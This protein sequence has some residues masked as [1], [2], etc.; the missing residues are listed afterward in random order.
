VR[1]ESIFHT[2][3]Q[4]GFLALSLRQIS[5]ECLI[6][7]ARRTFS[8]V[9]L[10]QLRPKNQIEART[11]TLSSRFGQNNF[12]FHTDFAFCPIPPRF[13]ILLNE[14][15]RTF[16]SSTNISRFSS[17][18]DDLKK[19]LMMSNWMHSRGVGEIQ[20]AGRFW[21]QNRLINRW[22]TNA[23]RPTNEHADA[24]VRPIDS[25]LARHQIPCEWRPHSAILIDNWAC[26]HSRDAIVDVEDRLNRELLRIEVWDYAGVDI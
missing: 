14:T 8:K 20:V 6:Q 7:R 3:E 25:A 19:Q 11:G 4:D 2:A 26:A 5:R 21:F 10:T 1:E 16:K 15:S 18:S 17:C 12:P 23:L 9:S 24:L 22:D 13:I